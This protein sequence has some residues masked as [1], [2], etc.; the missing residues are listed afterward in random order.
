MSLTSQLDDPASALSCFLDHTFPRLD[1]VSADTLTLLPARARAVPDHGS[2][3]PWTTIGTATDHRLRLAFTPHALPGPSYAE[4]DRSCNP[5]AIGINI[6]SSNQNHYAALAGTLSHQ[7][8]EKTRQAALQWERIA[9]FGR[10]LAARLRQTADRT[11]PHLNESLALPD[12]QEADLCRLCY[13]A[14]WLDELAHRP[15][16]EHEILNFIGKSGFRNLD[17]IL[18]VVPRLA[19]DD[20]AALVRLAAR[21]D[22]AGLRTRTDPDAV[23][24]GPLFPGGA[25]VGGADGDLIIAGTL[26]DI[27]TTMHPARHVRA[28]IRQLLGY[29]LIDYTSQHTI[30]GIGLYLARQAKMPTWEL[31]EL[32]PRL[33]ATAPLE[34]LRRQ[35]AKTLR[36]PEG[37]HST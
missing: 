8:G 10:S 2:V 3:V 5:I 27:K 21:S 14:A 18:A 25:D 24:S 17:D 29:V 20:M 26:I 9:A 28:G 30:T 32:L 19:V 31:D 12:P 34:I 16:E 23:T 6:A 4:P 37:R 33:G 1:E 7:G 36:Q 11:R 13:A 35:C 15:A 22:L